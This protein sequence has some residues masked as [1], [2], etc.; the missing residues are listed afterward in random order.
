MK[1]SI[2]FFLLF[3]LLFGS[4]QNLF[5]AI[6][7]S[8]ISC[9][10]SGT[11]NVYNVT[12]RLYRDCGGLEL[13]A[14][15]PTSL[16]SSCSISMLLTGASG[17]CNGVN[18]GSQS[19][20]VVT[21]LSGFDAIQNITQKTICSNCGS[22]TPGTFPIGVEVYT[23]QG[24]INLSSITCCKVR[25]SI[26]VG[27]KSSS[28]TVLVNPSNLPYYNEAIIDKCANFNGSP[29][30]DLTDLPFLINSNKF[31]V[32]DLSSDNN[33]KTDS[34][35]YEFS[36]IYTSNGVAATY[37]PGFSPTV[38]FPYIGSP[39]INP[40]FL[41]LTADGLLLFRPIG[42][43]VADVN[44]KRI[45]W[46]KNTSGI[47]ENIGESTTNFQITPYPNS[48]T[49]TLNL[50]TYDTL[51]IIINPPTTTIKHVALCPGQTYCEY[52][53]GTSS[54]LLDTT[55]LE[56][57]PTNF[58]DS[59]T[60][61]R[62]FN[63]ATRAT[64]GPRLD[65]ARFCWT[66]PDT[67][68]SKSFYTLTTKTFVKSDP[69]PTISYQVY[70]FEKSTSPPIL[71]LAKTKT[72][73]RKYSFKY[74]LFSHHVLNK[75]ETQ[76]KFETSPGS[77]VF[78]TIQADSISSKL[79]LKGGT[80]KFQLVVSNPC[81]N[82]I[83][84]DSIVIP[85]FK[86][87]AI[88]NQTNP[89][90]GDSKAGIST[91]VVENVGPV[92]YKI[93]NQ[94]YQN[95]NQFSGLPAGNYWIYAEDSVQQKDSVFISIQEPQKLV[96]NP[97][98]L[99][100]ILCFGNQN[101]KV[102][103]APINGKSPFQYKLENGSF[104]SSNLFSALGSGTKHFYVLDSNQCAADTLI[105]LANPPQ[106]FST[107]SSSQE[108]CLGKM[109][110]SASISISGGNPPTVINWQSNPIQQ[111]NNAFNIGSG[112][113]KAICIDNNN[114]T[115]QD[116]ILITPKTPF[117]GQQFC[118]IS[119][120]TSTYLSKLFWYKT[121]SVGTAKYLIYASLTPNGTYALIDSVPFDAP[122]PFMD[123]STTNPQMY[124]KI[125][126]VDSCGATSSFSSFHRAIHLGSTLLPSGVNLS[127]SLYEGASGS[128]QKV[129]RRSNNGSYQLL[130]S[131]SNT[132]TNYLDSF[133]A[134]GNNN[135]L[136]E[137]VKDNSCMNGSD[138][139]SVY[140]NQVSHTISTGMLEHKL[141]LVFKVYPNPSEGVLF[142]QKSSSAYPIEEIKMYTLEGKLVQTWQAT[143][144]QNLEELSIS[145]LENGYYQ[146][147]ISCKTV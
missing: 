4:N 54:S 74:V 22:R 27:S 105:S 73:T 30:A 49:S 87:S 76:W 51:G 72:S 118:A 11:P 70:Q 18:L 79:F 50:R 140:S 44:V 58:N 109:D 69:M 123:P 80:Y 12:V 82:Y 128:Q 3:F 146:L 116:S 130:S 32:I 124:Y 88:Q 53:V 48:S 21:A 92:V 7:G 137:W 112:W 61:Y 56:F 84:W 86:V 25:I 37:Q 8:Q 35:S 104:T 24:Q 33:P 9:Q 111:G 39:A 83:Y 57:K 29:F 113:L 147:L 75:F 95:S 142:I 13:C 138:L 133:P 1:T 31:Q 45:K 68:N 16:S 120:D 141:N 89:C 144:Q 126:T 106:F 81:G 115:Y 129:W 63:P 131:L 47:Y 41:Y 136:I 98:I 34:T 65:S 28:N 60:I 101:G 85:A 43:F 36:P 119:I 78:Q 90:F 46:R 100:D 117:S 96:L 6:V 20:Q 2:K 38:P 139:F 114:C 94:T 91:S 62:S 107:I 134:V 67:S 5:A 59:L 71:A 145:D 23:F 19:L 97:S 15:C 55:F 110:A 42:S 66:M 77:N 135:Y 108:S 143:E 17:T 103:L 93:N 14:N 121:P 99:Q 64:T 122:L 132:S 10:Q 125:K 52:V 40:A 102:Q 26:N 127:W